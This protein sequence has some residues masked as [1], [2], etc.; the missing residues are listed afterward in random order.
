M[1]N[2]VPLPLASLPCC[3]PPTVGC[4][5]SFALADSFLTCSLPG[6]G[7]CD[8]MPRSMAD[9]CGIRLAVPT[10]VY[11]AASHDVLPCEN[12]LPSD[13]LSRLC[14]FGL[15]F[16]DASLVG[17]HKSGLPGDFH[18]LSGFHG[19]AL[20][21]VCHFDAA[22]PLPSGFDSPFGHPFGRLSTRPLFGWFLLHMAIRG[23]GFLL[24]WPVNAGERVWNAPLTVQTSNLPQTRPELI[25]RGILQSD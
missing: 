8:H 23:L 21:S 14:S 12:G 6:S 5:S 24:G 17:V 22:E 13:W 11:H 18:W 19:P 15:S 25:V 7:F 20:D 4:Y 10:D 16:G 1:R 9:L 2:W 3:I